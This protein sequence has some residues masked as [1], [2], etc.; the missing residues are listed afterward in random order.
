MSNAILLD[1]DVL[2]DFLRGNY[3]AI[4]FIDEFSPHIIL[5]PIV[6]AELY[7]GVKGINELSVLDNFVS[8]FRVVPIDPDIAKSGGL[9]K[10]VSFLLEDL[11]GRKVEV[12]TP[13][14]FR[15]H[16]GPHILKE[17]E[18]VPFAA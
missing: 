11:L 15:P 3:K 10:P 9:Y 18:H 6:I 16:I 2:I 4:T 1:T 5:S 17:V 12:V 7:A 8:F 13:E 14:G